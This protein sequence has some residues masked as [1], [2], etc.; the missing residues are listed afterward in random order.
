MV[1]SA[2]GRDEEAFE[3]HLAGRDGGRD[4][5][6]VELQA[7]APRTPALMGATGWKYNPE[8]P[9]ENGICFFPNDFPFISPSVFI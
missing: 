6:T 9:P 3:H 4:A 7:H 2:A 1:S 5:T 8:T